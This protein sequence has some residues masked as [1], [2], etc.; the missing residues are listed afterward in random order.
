[1]RRRRSIIE[2]AAVTEV[3]NALFAAC[4]EAHP[5]PKVVGTD[6]ESLS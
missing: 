5:E 2:F 1:M 6:S 3:L 4:G